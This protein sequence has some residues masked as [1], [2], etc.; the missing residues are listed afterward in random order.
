MARQKLVAT[1]MRQDRVKGEVLR[2]GITLKSFC[3]NRQQILICRASPPILRAICL[4]VY[5]TILDVSNKP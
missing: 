4:A 3:I 2:V 5:M 1:L